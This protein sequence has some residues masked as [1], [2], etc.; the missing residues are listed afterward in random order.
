MNT[1]P[2]IQQNKRSPLESDP[3]FFSPIQ[4]RINNYIIIII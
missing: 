3:I 4:N 2:R 1:T